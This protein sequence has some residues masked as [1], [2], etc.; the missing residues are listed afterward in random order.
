MTAGFLSLESQPSNPAHH[1]LGGKEI[2]LKD[3]YRYLV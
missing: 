2:Q 3:Q 1:T